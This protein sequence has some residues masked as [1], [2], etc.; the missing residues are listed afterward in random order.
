MATGPLAGRPHFAHDRAMP[1]REN[2]RVVYS[3]DAGRVC[4]GC[5][6]PARTCRC[7]TRGADEAVPARVVA[8]LRVERAGRGGKTVTVVYDLPRNGAF[9]KDLAQELK[10][11]CGAGG[12]VQDGAV[13]LQGDLRD[14]VRDLLLKKGFGVKG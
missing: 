14:R 8:R 6:W 7:S 10:R 5:G 12:T 4:P 3:T 1:A 9:L 2:G 13:E 11:A